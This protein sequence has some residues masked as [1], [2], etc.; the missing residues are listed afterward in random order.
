M[1]VPTTSQH[2]APAINIQ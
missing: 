2:S 1:G